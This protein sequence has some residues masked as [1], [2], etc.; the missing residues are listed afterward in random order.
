[1]SALSQFLKKEGERLRVEAPVREAKQQDWDRAVTNLLRQLEGWVKEA[2]SEGIIQIEVKKWPFPISEE[3]LGEYRLPYLRLRLDTRTV[4]I[5]GKARNVVDRIRPPGSAHSR[6]ADG[7]AVISDNVVKGQSG[8]ANYYLYRLAEP[9]GDHWY[10]RH[11]L[12]EEVKPLDRERFE[13][14]LVSLL[15]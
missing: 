13:A 6:Q 15:K 11:A 7:L 10:I 1:M 3:G 4:T 12:E 9:D 5:S 8:T 14:I 2:D